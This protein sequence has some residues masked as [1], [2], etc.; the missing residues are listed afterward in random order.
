MTFQKKLQISRKNSVTE[1]AV[2]LALGLG[3]VKA[4]LTL[5][6]KQLHFIAVLFYGYKIRL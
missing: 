1:I 4:K 6:Y 5:T 3:L 2:W